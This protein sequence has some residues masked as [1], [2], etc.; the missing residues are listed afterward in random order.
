MLIETTAKGNMS[1]KYLTTG[2]VA[3]IYSVTP[4]TVLKWIKKGKIPASRTAGGHYRVR[5]EDLDERKGIVAKSEPRDAQQL[6]PRNFQYCWEFN[7][8]EGLV[9]DQCR[10]CAVF[11]LRAYRCYEVMKL[12][13]EA[14][15]SRIFCT[16]TCDECDYFNTVHK[17]DINVLV[18]SDNEVFTTAL[19]RDASHSYLNMNLAFSACE[20]T[21][22]AM[23]EQFK[24]DYA[25]IDCS[26]GPG[27]SRE[28]AR[29]LKADP[30]IPFVRVILA[31]RNG[32]YPEECDR[33]VFARI[34]SPIKVGDLTDCIDGVRITDEVQADRVDKA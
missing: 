6:T 28:F 9:Q 25:V 23:V 34:G 31:A 3:K 18:V 24:P 12:A 4:D 16:K 11:K 21:T 20:Y 19:R 33:D 13:P 8:S 29:H 2:Q 22:S 27:R 5:R 17:Q 26:L 1:S 14:G 7:S 32:E 15:H 30:R 10:E